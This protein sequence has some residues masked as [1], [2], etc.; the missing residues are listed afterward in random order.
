MTTEKTRSNQADEPGECSGELLLVDKPKGWTSFDVVNRIR[1]ILGVRRV[2]HAGTLDPLA[3]GLLIVCTG[4]RTRELQQFQGWDKEYIV[5][6]TL[7]M[8]TASYDAETPAVEQRGHEGIDEHAIRSM[9]P[10][11]LGRQLQLPPMYSAAKVR[12][13]RL[14]KYAR[15][16]LE[17]ER[18][19]REVF[20][21]S[22][23]IV[24]V[25]LPDVVLKVVCTKGTYMRT[26]VHDFGAALGCGA[27]VR[28]LRRTRIGDF[29]LEDAVSLELIER[30]AS[31]KVIAEA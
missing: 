5:I 8:V 21:S 29:H 4:R 22:M 17:I 14:Y 7:G 11:F 18:G 20:I 27:Y 23:E 28:E 26:L 31:P 19:P 30:R 10:R 2:G 3:T 12:G 16:G 13:R 25:D 15:R 9:I 6:M 1:G 24:R